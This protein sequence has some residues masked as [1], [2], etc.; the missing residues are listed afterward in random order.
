MRIDGWF[1]EGFGVFHDYEVKDLPPGLVVFLGPNETGKSTLLAFLR[2]VLFGFAARRNAS[3]YPPLKGGRHGGRVF[4]EASGGLVTVERYVGRRHSLRVALPWSGEDEAAGLARILGGADDKLFRSVFAFS[5]EELQT[6]ESLEA[7][8]IRERIYSAHI[9]GAGR[10]ARQ[11]IAALEG[12]MAA[13]F[14]PRGASRIGELAARAEEIAA[15]WRQA[16]EQAE[17][18]PALIREVETHA[19]EVAAL[20]REIAQLQE[21]RRRGESLL[22]LRPLWRVWSQRIEQ[23]RQLAM[24]LDDRLAGIAPAVE[25]HYTALPLHEER[26]RQWPD[27]RRRNVKLEEEL[28]RWY[29]RLGEDWSGDLQAG[30]DPEELAG[31]AR[32]WAQRIAQIGARREEAERLLDAA[33]TEARRIAGELQ[34]TLDPDPGSLRERER[35]LAR[36]RPNLAELAAQE[37]AGEALEAARRE[38]VLR[39]TWIL[40]LVWLGILVAAIMSDWMSGAVSRTTLVLLAVT[41]LA[42]ILGRFFPR[43]PGIQGQLGIDEL[44]AVVARD[45]ATLGLRDP[46]EAEDLE[47]VASSLARERLHLERREALQGDLLRARETEERRKASLAALA[48]EASSEGQAWNAWKR[49]RGFPEAIAAAEAVEYAGW[50]DQARQAY[51]AREEVK[52]ETR[53]LALEL[54]AWERPVRELLGSTAAGE[55]LVAELTL[56]HGRCARDRRRR[57]EI[58]LLDLAIEEARFPEELESALAAAGEGEV[59]AARPADRLTEAQGQRDQAL[60]RWR[61]AGAARADLEQSA[62][63]AALETEL[64]TVRAEIAGAAREW[65]VA[66]LAKGLVER[67]LGEYT[68]I[69]QPG[70]LREASESFAR[71]TGGAYRRVVQQDEGLLAEDRAG[72]LRRPEELSRGAMEQLFLCLRLGLAEEFGRRGAPLP[73]VMDDVLVNFD[74]RRARAMAAEIRRFAHSRQVL[75]FTCHPETAGMLAEDGA[76]PVIELSGDGAT[77]LG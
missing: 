29:A 5:L 7:G 75:F 66:A 15:A 55:A 33:S 61:I 54:G 76:A 60:G 8:Q 38:A 22:A 59:E 74:P 16:R 1:I 35:A 44:R 9:L 36:I 51:A 30:G 45:A 58:A 23:R 6:L 57:E 69:H 3:R 32:G 19:A 2:G 73:L 72:A 20:E 21:Q 63:V 41:L 31:E 56:L 10:P 13:L 46:P 53:R 4:L 68:R 71:V 18:Y 50:V 12:R 14:R 42:L 62:D 70:V 67:T 28:G 47:A 17:R 65:A 39:Q 25:A 49:S 27:T 37:R 64:E 34:Q 26:L 52:A 43:A 77:G 48:G 11:V 40:W 24:E